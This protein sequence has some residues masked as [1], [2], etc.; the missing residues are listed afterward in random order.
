[1]WGEWPENSQICRPL[2]IIFIQ[3]GPHMSL[4]TNGSWLF[5]G[6]ESF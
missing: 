5:L 3:F 1:M 2:W 4:L 6:Q